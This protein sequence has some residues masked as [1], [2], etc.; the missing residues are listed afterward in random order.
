LEKEKRVLHP[1]EER[2]E[3]SLSNEKRGKGKKVLKG[4]KTGICWILSSDGKN[5]RRRGR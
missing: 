2:K 5:K 4:K 3:T 1:I